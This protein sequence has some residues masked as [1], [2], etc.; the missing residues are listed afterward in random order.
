MRE[1]RLDNLG[2]E[3]KRRRV[4]SVCKGS[5]VW[6]V[7]CNLCPVMCCAAPRVLSTR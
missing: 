1:I 3:R 4:E 5:G 2:L 7:E 6:W